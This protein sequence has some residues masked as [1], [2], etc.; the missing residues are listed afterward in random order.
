MAIFKN[1]IIGWSFLRAVNSLQKKTVGQLQSNYG[2]EGTVFDGNGIISCCVVCFNHDII[3]I[4]FDYVK[5]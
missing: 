2:V 1:T 4:M 3:A 5:K